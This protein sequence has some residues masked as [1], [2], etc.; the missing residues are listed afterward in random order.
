MFI[1][2]LEDF[3]NSEKQVAEAYTS[4]MSTMRRMIDDEVD[5]EQNT[6]EKNEKS[7]D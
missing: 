3:N 4:F 6:T 2:P 5:N 1:W 7:K